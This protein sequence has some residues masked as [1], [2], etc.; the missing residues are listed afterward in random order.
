MTQRQRLVAGTFLLS[1]GFYLSCLSSTVTYGGDSG[2]LIAASY[3]LGIPHPTGYPFYCLLGNLFAHLVP[4]GEIAWRYNLLSAVL[5]SLSVALVTATVHR[6][7]CPPDNADQSTLDAVVNWSAV[8][9]GLLL[10]GF[11]YFSSQAV[12]TEVYTLNAAF[13]MA[14]LL[15]AVRWQQSH[16][17]RLFYSLALLIGVAFTAHLSTIFLLPGLF[18]FAILAQRRYLHGQAYLIALALFGAGFTLTLYLPIRSQLFPAPPENLLFQWWPLDWGHPTSFAAWKSHVTGQQYKHL[19][20]SPHTFSLFGKEVVLPWFNASLWQLPGKIWALWQLM[21][22]QLMWCTPLIFVGAW[23]AFRPEFGGRAFGFMLLSTW[24]LNV[25]V[26]LNYEVSDVANFFFPA[27]LV[28]AVWLGLGLHWFLSLVKQRGHV[29]DERQVE[30]STLWSWRMNTVASLA[31]LGTIVVQWGASWPITSWRGQTQA[32]DRALQRAA[33]LEKLASS[34]GKQPY[35]LLLSNDQLW[36]FWYAQFVLDQ[37]PKVVTPWGPVGSER[38]KNSPLDEVTAQL[39]E[40]GPVTLGHWYESVDARFPYEMLTEDGNLCLASDRILP[41]AAQIITQTPDNKPIQ[42][43]YFRRTAINRRTRSSDLPRAGND[44][45]PA[46]D[47]AVL[48]RDDLAAFEVELNNPQWPQLQLA[49][50]TFDA[51]QGAIHVGFIEV[52][53]VQRGKLDGPPTPT[54]ERIY[55]S[56]DEVTQ[57]NPLGKPLQ[58]WKQTRR[59]IVPQNAPGNATLRAAVPLQVEELA[60]TATYEVWVRLVRSRDDQSTLWTLC[61]AVQLTHR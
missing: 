7:L 13:I 29:L 47:I 52:L 25:G 24:L 10:T 35:A 60:P 4:L 34:T 14:L 41:P 53:C 50:P 1:L 3:R 22:L 8:G 59:L 45:L 61:D 11:F 46:R 6:L 55:G 56:A 31:L 20:M 12:L 36:P 18:V 17:L 16:D 9:A 57:L 48:K 15:L 32:R 19:L 28:Q 23:R 49:T 21:A 37:A 44:S 40:R 30:K 43:A 58:G 39:K 26:Q 2:E 27:Y 54:V 51:Q 42:A 38:L 5:G 33:A